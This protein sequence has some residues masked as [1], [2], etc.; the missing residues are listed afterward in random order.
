[1]H[2]E[3]E[4]SLSYSISTLSYIMSKIPHTCEEYTSIF[5]MLTVIV[6]F[7]CITLPKAIMFY[8]KCKV[9]RRRFE[10]DNDKTS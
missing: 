4:E 6:T 7:F 2:L 10:K 8:K 3:W 5:I 9:R 1:M